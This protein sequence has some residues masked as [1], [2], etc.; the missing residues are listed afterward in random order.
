MGPVGVP[1]IPYDPVDDASWASASLSADSAAAT[2]S[3]TVL[4]ASGNP[5]AFE[6]V[7]WLLQSGPCYPMGQTNLRPPVLY[8]GPETDNVGKATLTVAWDSTSAGSCLV[9]AQVDS[10]MVE[11]RLDQALSD[12]AKKA[13]PSQSLDAFQPP[14]LWVADGSVGIQ[15]DPGWMGGA[16]T[17][18]K[19][20]SGLLGAS[21]VLVVLALVVSVTGWALAHAGG[22]N[23]ATRFAKGIAVALFAAAA[24]AS[25]VVLVAWG[26]NLIPRI[27]I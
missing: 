21:I 7:K 3:A 23:H 25:L 19:V 27:T 5:V 4:D 16:G 15:L 24:L 13:E 9:K 17:L 12:V 2:F 20:A 18:Q 14:N 8:T 6:P 22:S 11:V 10:G 26:A 1:S